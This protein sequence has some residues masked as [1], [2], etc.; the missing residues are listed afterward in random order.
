LNYTAHYGIVIEDREEISIL[1]IE[2]VPLTVFHN[3]HVLN[4]FM[5]D[6]NSQAEWV[7]KFSTPEK[8][9]PERNQT[10]LEEKF[11]KIYS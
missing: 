3:H 5:D 10:G 9:Y 2:P 11:M 6:Y 7:Q 8:L 4:S 1:D